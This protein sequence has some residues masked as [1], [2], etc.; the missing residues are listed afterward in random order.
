MPAADVLPWIAARSA[1]AAVEAARA[2]AT[3]PEPVPG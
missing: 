2:C 3:R 1:Q